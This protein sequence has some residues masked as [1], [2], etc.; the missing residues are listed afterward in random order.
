M[1]VRKIESSDGD[2]NRTIVMIKQVG[3]ATDAQAMAAPRYEI[4]IRLNDGSVQA[5]PTDNPA[6]WRV[7]E[8][9][10]LIAGA[11]PARERKVQ[12]WTK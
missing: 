5:I 8:R 2:L 10:I 12:N 7:G 1:E 3:R 9:M 6:N 11:N 4:I